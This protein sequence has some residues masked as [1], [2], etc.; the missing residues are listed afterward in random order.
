MSGGEGTRKTC[1]E[2]VSEV[3][4]VDKHISRSA[5]KNFIN[6]NKSTHRRERHKTVN[7]NKITYKK[8]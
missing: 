1:A 6:L 2:C 4:D 7:N 8:I 5:E 3:T